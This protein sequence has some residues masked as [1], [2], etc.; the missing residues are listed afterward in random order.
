MWQRTDKNGEIH[1]EIGFEVAPGDIRKWPVDMWSKA[2]PPAKKLQ[3]MLLEQRHPD[4]AKQTPQDEVTRPK[5]VTPGPGLP[6]APVAASKLP[7]DF[8]LETP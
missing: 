1:T 7:K 6:E 3:R 5:A 4:I 2:Q 8:E